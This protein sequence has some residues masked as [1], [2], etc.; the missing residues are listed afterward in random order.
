VKAIV[1]AAGRG[2]RMRPLTDSVPKPLLR[3]G[4]RSLIEWQILRLVRAGV[5][6]IVVNVSHLAGE[7]ERSLG[8][9]QRLGA[10]IEY[11]YETEALETAGGIARALPLLG[12]EPFI[13]VNADIY[14]EYDYAR[15][16]HAAAALAEA[17]ARWVAFLVLV[18]NPE[19]HR[20]GDFSL[21][22]D[23]RVCPCEGESL[24][25]SGIGVYRPA[26]FSGI[27]AGE[28]KALG[29]MLHARARAGE[30]RG[31]CFTGRWMDIGTPQRLARLQRLLGDSGE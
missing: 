13:A 26:L 27:G 31:E 29:P 17:N 22:G 18:P 19:H 6:R 5:T 14:C 23:G 9:G 8:P 24:T 21:A 20:R 16:R 3:A 15:L 7:I 30:L 4:G 28:R 2:E 25:F 10:R 11:S 12:P 1:L